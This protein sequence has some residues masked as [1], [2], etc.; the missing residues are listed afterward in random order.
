MVMNLITIAFWLSI[1]L[2]YLG[3][4]FQYQ[5]IVIGLSALIIGIVAVVTLVQ[6]RS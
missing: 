3:F 6:S 5:E 1:G 4:N 2:L